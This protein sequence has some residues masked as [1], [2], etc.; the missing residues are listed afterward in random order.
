[1]SLNMI[2]KIYISFYFYVDK[3]MYIFFCDFPPLLRILESSSFSI[4][5][6][7]LHFYSF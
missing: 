5:L 4:D 2:F 6:I 3:S 7:N 1:M